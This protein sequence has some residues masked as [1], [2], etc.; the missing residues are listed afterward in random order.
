LEKAGFRVLGI[1]SVGEVLHGFRS[2]GLA[3]SAFGSN[4]LPFPLQDLRHFITGRLLGGGMIVV[5][6]KNGLPHND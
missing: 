3:R 1:E 6:K 5:A 2:M 4:G